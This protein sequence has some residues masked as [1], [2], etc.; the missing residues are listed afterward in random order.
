[1]R[2]INVLVVDDHPFSA[3]ACVMCW[4]PSKICVSFGRS[5]A[6]AKRRCGSF[7][8]LKPDVVVMDVN[9]P[10]L[11]GIQVTRKLRSEQSKSN[12][13]ILTALR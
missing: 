13:V 8:E 1:M 10:S 7:G 9:I 11:N 5:Q 2:R 6:T 3:R 4:R 12:V